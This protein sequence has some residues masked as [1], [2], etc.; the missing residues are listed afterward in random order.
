L[1]KYESREVSFD[2]PRHWADRSIVAFVAP[3]KPGRDASANVVMTRDELRE[4]EGLGAYTDRQ[5]AQLAGKLDGFTLLER[6]DREVGGRVGVELRFRARGARGGLSQR[7]VIVTAR[8]TAF[9][10]T[11]TTSDEDAAQNDPLFDRI[12]SSITL[13]DAAGDAKGEEAGSR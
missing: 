7:M 10:F 2:V 11:T 8:K 13:T 12:L 3:K 5:I 4:G 6:V 1:P 9:T